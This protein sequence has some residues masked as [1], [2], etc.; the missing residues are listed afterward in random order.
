MGAGVKEF[1]TE[2]L[3]L[4]GIGYGPLTFGTLTKLQHALA[5]GYVEG[6]GQPIS[7]SFRITHKGL[8]YIKDESLPD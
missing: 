4:Y 5:L 8:E 7:T 6:Y 3:I 2:W 1:L